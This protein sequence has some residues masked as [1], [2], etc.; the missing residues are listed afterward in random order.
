MDKEDEAWI[1]VRLMTLIDLR[2]FL[3]VGRL[4]GKTEPRQSFPPP[5]RLSSPYLGKTVWVRERSVS[6][7]EFYYEIK[8]SRGLV[9]LSEWIEHFAR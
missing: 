3:D 9:V 1:R 8:D 4:L 2:I 5:M 6:S 7:M